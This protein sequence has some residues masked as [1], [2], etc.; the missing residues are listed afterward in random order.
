[1]SQRWLSSV[2]ERLA[3]STH[4]TGAPDTAAAPRETTRHDDTDLDIDV[5][6]CVNVSKGTVVAERVIWATGAAKRRGL[7]ER[8]SL[9]MHE[10]MY[11]VPCQWI[12]MFGMRFPIDVAFLAADGRVLAVHHALRPNRLSRLVVRAAGVLELAVGALSASQ[13]TVDDCLELLDP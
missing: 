3:P 4:G 9:A 1:M 11:L 10:G 13:T 12:H 5:V 7:L 6:R 2:V 8:D